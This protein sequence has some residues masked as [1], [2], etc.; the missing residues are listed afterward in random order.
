MDFMNSEEK[1]LPVERQRFKKIVYVVK[2][3]V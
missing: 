2:V 1:A 3:D